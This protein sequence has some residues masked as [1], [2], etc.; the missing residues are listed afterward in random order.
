MEPR[1]PTLRSVA[2]LWFGIAVAILVVGFRQAIFLTPT[3]A[4]QGDVGRI[5][6][7]HVPIAMLSLLFPYPT[8]AASLALVQGGG[9]DPL[10][11][12]T[13]DAFAL[14]SAEVAVVYTSICLLS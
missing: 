12:L 10:K 13:A 4:A 6:Y 5:F 8:S 7:Y 1:T 2:W 3:D 14:A 9:R 11:A